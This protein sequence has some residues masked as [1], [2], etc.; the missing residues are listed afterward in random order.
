M[1]VIEAYSA[2]TGGLLQALLGIVNRAA[3]VARDEQMSESPRRRSFENLSY[4]EKIISDFDIFSLSTRCKRTV[5]H[6]D[7]GKLSIR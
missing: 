5:V 3:I 7:I 4:G 6:P 1:A 2:N